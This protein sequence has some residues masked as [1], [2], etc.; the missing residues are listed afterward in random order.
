M[1]RVTRTSTAS[2]RPLRKGS[3]PRLRGKLQN[4]SVATKVCHRQTGLLLIREELGRET[5]E[6]VTLVLKILYHLLTP[7]TYDSRTGRKKKHYCI[8][9]NHSVLVFFFSFA[10]PAGIESDSK[11]LCNCIQVRDLERRG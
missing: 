8:I 11:A 4:S 7:A 6:I 1:C 9:K 10:S 2:T 5:Q 3:I